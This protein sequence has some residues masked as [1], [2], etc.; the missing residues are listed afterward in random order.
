[1]KKAAM[2]CIW[3]G[4]FSVMLA[5]LSRIMMRPLI[6]FGLESRAFGGFAALAFLLAIA[7]EG[8]QGAR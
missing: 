6:G 4:L 8:M 1:M 7:L 3:I 5:I 2:V